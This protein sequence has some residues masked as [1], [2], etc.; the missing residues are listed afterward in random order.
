M[1]VTVD[2]QW[3]QAHLQEISAQTM[4]DRKMVLPGDQDHLIHALLC[5]CTLLH[6][7]RHLENLL[8]SKD[9]KMQKLPVWI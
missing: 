3:I 2:I 5:A 8:H 1:Q 9:G 4:D 6:Q 7:R